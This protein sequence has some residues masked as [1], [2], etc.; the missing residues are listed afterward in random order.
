MT[1]EQAT[2]VTARYDECVANADARIGELLGALETLGLRDRTLIVL[3]SDHGE[4]MNDNQ[5]RFHHE[6]LFE[7][8]MHVPFV[9]SGPGVEALRPH[10][11][12]P[13]SLV[14]IFPT[15]A[16]MADLTPPPV[17]SGISLASTEADP[18]R[19]ILAVE[20]VSGPAQTRSLRSGDWK[21]I[22]SADR[23]RSLVRISAGDRYN[24]ADVN[25]VETFPALAE[26]LE[27]ELERLFLVT[28]ENA[29]PSEE[30]T[31]ELDQ[32]RID[33]LKAL[34]YL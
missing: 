34:G 18:Q 26:S 4:N 24:R 30:G 9:M 5:P 11:N 2:A 14:D 27:A 23:G 6:G 29:Y 32:E 17:L 13:V 20:G 16:D 15:L 10:A 31:E 7:A 33:Q 3:T 19:P 8:T 12:A 22:H 21:L 25:E 1:A 28:E